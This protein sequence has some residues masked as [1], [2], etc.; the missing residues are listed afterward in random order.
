[1]AA[2]TVADLPDA[3]IRMIDRQVAV[4]GES[5]AK[6]APGGVESGSHHIVEDEVRF[7]FGLVEVVL[8]LPDLLGIVAPIPRL[9]RL[10]QSFGARDLLEFCQ[11]G[12]GFGL[13]RLPDL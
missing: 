5:D 1:M 4:L 3:H 7:Y 8:G 10:V 9:D 2:G 12:K 13:R 11:L 6:Q